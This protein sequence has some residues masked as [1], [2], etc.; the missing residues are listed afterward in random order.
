MTA[1]APTRSSARESLVLRLERGTVPLGFVREDST[2]YLVGRDRAASWPVALLREGV[3]RFLVE[4]EERLGA[5]ELVVR[6][7]EKQSILDRFLEKYGAERFERWYDHP[8]RVLRIRLDAPPEGAPP[9][10]YYDWLRSEFDNVAEE[11]DRHITGNRINRLLRDRSLAQLRT[12]FDRSHALLEIGCGS[13][14]ETI[15]LLRDG[16]E[17]LCVDISERMLEVV[18]AKAHREGLGERLRTARLPAG[19]LSDL[20]PELGPASFDGAYSTYGALNCEADL[21]GVPPAL[22][23]LLSDRGR[24]LAAVYNR[25]CAFELVGYTLT[26]QFGRAFGRSGTPVRV[27]SSRF[28]VDV[29]AYSPPTFER[30]FAPWFDRVQ[31]MAVPAVLP[32]SDLAGYAEKFARRFAVLDRWDRF[33]SP[34]WPFRAL[35]D[36]FLMVLG[37]SDR[38][39]ADGPPSGVG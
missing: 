21:R 10:H 6:P 16:H 18:R 20:V 24:F 33:L 29:F 5:A 3:G 17:I 25:W 37:R 31:L 27:G 22:H 34:R 8:A 15:P 2:L 11:Y 1:G 38:A 35:G 12:V 36:H 14:M 19:A 4:G 39:T 9:D 13:G 28:C 32:P 7:D 26:G 30:I 23:R